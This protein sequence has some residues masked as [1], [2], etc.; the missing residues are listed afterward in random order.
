VSRILECELKLITFE[1][2]THLIPSDIFLEV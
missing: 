1:T 2:V